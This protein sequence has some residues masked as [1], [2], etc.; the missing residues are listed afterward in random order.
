[1]VVLLTVS[2]TIGGA[3]VADALAGGGVGV[4][5]GSVVNNQYSPLID[6]SLNTGA[7]TLFIRHDAVSDP[8]T[9]VSTY[10]QP[11]GTLTSFAY[12]GADSAAN[13]FTAL[14]ALGDASGNSKNNADGLSGG[15]WIDM[16][17]DASSINQ[18]NI[19]SFPDAVKRYGENGT[20]GSTLNDSFILN[21]Q[22]MVYDAPGEVPAVTPE[23]GKIGKAG[24][25]TLG[26]NG[27]IKLRIYLPVSYLE[28]GIVQWDYAIAYTAI[29]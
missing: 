17:A 5:Y 26:D 8:I 16:D 4:D 27:K 15:I 22:A 29:A 12:A 6:K 9:D 11:Y 21:E 25:V 10:I 14:L 28:G 13:D 24:D 19:G 20:D 1:M 23:A 2:E 3:A 18:F 7:K